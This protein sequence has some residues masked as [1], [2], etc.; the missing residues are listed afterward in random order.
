MGH[1]GLW[2]AEFGGYPPR[3]YFERIDPRLPGILATL[4]NECWPADTVSGFLT[5]E[6]AALLGLPPGIPVTVGAID[7]HVGGVGGGVSPGRMV[8]VVGTSTCELLAAPKPP[9]PE[10]PIR[11]ICGQVDGSVVPGLIGYEAG[12]S[13]FGD[14]YAWFK[15][16]LLWPLGLFSGPEGADGEFRE[17]IGRTLASKTIPALEK[18]AETL[19]PGSGGLCALDWLNGRRTPDV[20]PLVKGALTGL[21]LGAGAPGVFRALVEGTAFGVRAITERFR[22]EGIPVE[23]IAAVGG[24]ARKSSFVM[25]VVADVLNMPIEIAAE[26]QAVALGSAMFA[27]AAAGLYPNVPAAQRGM[28]SPIEKTYVPNPERAELY[29]RLYGRYKAL[30][31]FIED[32]LRYAGPAARK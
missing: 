31:A 1:K 22:E 9:G 17:R 29:D 28:G 26:D 24:I 23:T 25:Q 4:G 30:G 12:Q 15:D 7:A 8:L 32:S 19:P 18:A 21:T 14:V 20:N 3:E 13:A 16:L 2:H 11:G 10:K 27:A 6:W 5:G